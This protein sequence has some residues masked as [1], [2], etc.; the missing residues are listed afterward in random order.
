MGW[1]SNFSVFPLP[2]EE[3]TGCLF[4]VKAF[5][6]GEPRSSLADS[7]YALILKSVLT[8]AITYIQ[9]YRPSQVHSFVNFP[10]S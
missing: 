9:V 10:G 3:L 5:L 4:L 8:W 6:Y 7:P 1:K 2:I